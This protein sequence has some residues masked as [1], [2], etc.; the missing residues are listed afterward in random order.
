MFGLGGGLSNG[1]KNRFDDTALKAASPTAGRKNGCDELIEVH[2]STCT[3]GDLSSTPTVAL[4]GDSH[5]ATITKRLDEV[6]KS[7]GISALVYAQA[8]GVPLVDVGT[9]E[10]KKNPGSRDFMKTA[11]SEI[12]QNKNIKTV[13]IVSQ[14]PIYTTGRKPLSVN[15]SFYS[16]EYTKVKSL[17]ENYDVF[18]RGLK[19]T[20]DL[21]SDK[22]V[23]IAGS[24]PEYST[25]V[26][27]AIATNYRIWGR[28]ALTDKQVINEE[29][30]KKRNENVLRAFNSVGVYN[31]TKYI[32]TYNLYCTTGSCDYID[33]DMNSYYTD[34]D[35]VSYHGSKILV[36]EIYRLLVL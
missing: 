3:I 33:E 16:D 14:W 1:Y 21:L 28:L 17:D 32:D 6:L 29:K 11:Y 30:Y 4:I 34:T 13:V 8:Y 27:D 35:H 31:K 24:I 7:G 9:D 2:G 25:V 12:I 36:D 22:D 18:E 5:S 19:R 26:P 10:P 15:P 23:I 20:I